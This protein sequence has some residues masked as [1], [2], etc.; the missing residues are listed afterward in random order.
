MKQLP[1]N[2]GLYVTSLLCAGV[3]STAQAGTYLFSED[4]V[5]GNPPD[6]DM[7]THP[8]GYNV[9]TGSPAQFD[10]HVCTVPGQPN[11]ADIQVTIANAVDVF[12][13]AVP[14]SRNL[15]TDD[16]FDAGFA[17]D[18]QSVATHEIGHCLGL[19]HVNAASESGF[20][21]ARSDATKS[22]RGANNQLDPGAGADGLH[23]SPDDLRGD[24]VNLHYFEPGVNDPFRILLEVDQTNFTRDVAQLPPGDNYVANADRAVGDQAR[25]DPSGERDPC[26]DLSGNNFFQ[27]G[28]QCQESIM[29]Q[30]SGPLEYQRALSPGD[31]AALAYARSGLDRL[32]GTADDYQPKLVF[33]GS[34]TAPECDINISFDNTK[35]GFAVCQAGFNSG[36]ASYNE[37]LSAIGLTSADAYFNT[38]SNWRFA[39]VRIPLAGPDQAMVAPASATT[40][41]INLLDNDVNQHG[42][43]TLSVTPQAFGGPLS[44]TVAINTDGTFTYTNTDANATQDYFVYEVCLS[45]ANA[46]GVPACGYQ[47]VTLTV[48]EDPAY[49]KDGFE[50]SSP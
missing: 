39:D 43:G 49:F 10:V 45:I 40:P 24:D 5:F 31:V 29:Q 26:R 36:P 46:S 41:S 1:K 28:N 8:I 6:P 11:D 13:A 21:D 27:A 25:Y 32:A 48:G 18:F 12:N 17:L 38:N 2:P 23:G 3:F 20:G 44:G 14:V 4:T 37:V 47:L 30:G 9:N 22:L 50:G 42:S 15:I 16:A 35:T 33:L 7:V 19:A 34:S